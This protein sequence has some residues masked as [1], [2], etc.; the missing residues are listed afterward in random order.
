M[1][2]VPALSAAPA[3]AAE[4]GDAE[5]KVV[6]Q[7]LFDEARKLSAE[8]KHAEACPKFAESQKLDPTIP[9]KFY[10][11]E[12]LEKTG[13]IASAWM[14]YV[15][16]ADSLRSGGHLDRE[17][18]V[19]E[20]SEALKPRLARLTVAV[21]EEVRALPDLEIRRDGVVMGRAQ[22]NVPI[23]SDS[24][25]HVISVSAAGKKTWETRVSTAEEGKTVTVDVPQPEEAPLPPP[26][27]VEPPPPVGPPVRVEPLAAAGVESSRTSPLRTTGFVAGG[28]GAAGLLAGLVSGVLAV[29]KKDALEGHCTGNV[30]DATGVDTYRS[31]ATFADVSTAG[32]LVGGVLLVGGAAMVLL[33]P[34]TPKSAGF[35]APG[36]EIGLGGASVHGRWW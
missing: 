31:A 19:R 18:S 24:G 26:A 20:R 28:V 4:P 16:V 2:A 8:G 27:V 21:P 30:C 3:R 12:C 6:A 17:K 35:G 7:A 15:E 36:V 22:W 25:E 14:Y 33:A 11:A 32:L 13:R 1:L 5:E 34:S 9:T 23:P 10:L 29:T